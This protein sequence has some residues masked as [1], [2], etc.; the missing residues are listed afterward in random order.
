MATR[1]DFLRTCAGAGALCALP[2]IDTDCG[3]PTKPQNPVPPPPKSV[4][5]DVTTVPAL[6]TENSAAAI[7]VSS[8]A[9]I[10]VTRTTGDN[11]FALSRSC[12]HRGCTVRTS[13]PTLNCPCHGSK[14][15]LDGTVAHGPA[16]RPLQSWTVTKTGNILTIRFV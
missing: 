3:N 1:R 15:N 7:A 16:T 6:A 10:F 13:V 12:T 11:Y 9:T 8:A 14:F 5:L 2:W 4:D